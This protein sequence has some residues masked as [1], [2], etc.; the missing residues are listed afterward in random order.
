M[1]TIT[2]DVPATASASGR[3]SLMSVQ[4]PSSISGV[5]RSADIPVK[6]NA[7]IASDSTPAIWLTACGDGRIARCSASAASVIARTT[8]AIR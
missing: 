4:L 5:M 8:D 6:C 2:S 7:R 1:Q 3:I